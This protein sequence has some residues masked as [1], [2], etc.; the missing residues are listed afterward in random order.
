MDLSNGMVS[1]I[2][3]QKCGAELQQE[4][5]ALAPLAPGEVAVTDA[6][7]LQCKY[8]FHINL[9]SIK[10]KYSTEVRAIS[11]SV[12]AFYILVISLIKNLKFL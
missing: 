11:E 6:Y 10:E 3:L 5:S 7:K 12:L 1:K 4:C 9:K 8:I 2:L